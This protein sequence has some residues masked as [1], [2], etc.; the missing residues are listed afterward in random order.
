MGG[1][2]YSTAEWSQRLKSVRFITSHISHWN[3]R[4]VVTS[5]PG[6]LP[7]NIKLIWI[8][9]GSYLQ[10]P[11]RDCAFNYMGLTLKQVV[12]WFIIFPLFYTV[13]WLAKCSVW[14]LWWTRLVHAVC[15]IVSVT[16][17]ISVVFEPC[18]AEQLDNP[19]QVHKGGW[20]SAA[21]GQLNWAVCR[22]C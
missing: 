22:T 19:Q 21:S 6:L 3:D 18:D 2:L 17:F 9:T 8:V 11:D 1:L 4:L 10:P 16:V 20:I 13:S 7:S 5:E 15:L 14:C 12:Q